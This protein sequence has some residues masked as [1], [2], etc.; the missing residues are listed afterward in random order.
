MVNTEESIGTYYAVVTGS[1]VKDTAQEHKIAA[2]STTNNDNGKYK[3]TY[4]ISVS[5]TGLD[6]ITGL[7]DGDGAVVIKASNDSE[8]TVTFGGETTATVT[9]AQLKNGAQT[10]TATI[11]IVG[12]QNAEIQADAYLVNR[13]DPQNYLASLDSSITISSAKTAEDGTGDFSCVVVD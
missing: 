9:L 2:L 12:N 10:V 5:A 13:D 8:A 1:P 3:C 4:N 11:D 7:V 6:K